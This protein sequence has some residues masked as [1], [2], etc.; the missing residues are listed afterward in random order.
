ME[1]PLAFVS[2]FVALAAAQDSVPGTAG[3]VSRLP[4]AFVENA[5]QWDG[6]VAFRARRGG[7]TL[8]AGRDGFLLRLVRME[9]EE[10]VRGADH[11]FALV[12]E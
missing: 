12:G 2:L 1:G 9:D 4:L 7:M 5:G 8:D 6:E 11:P 10:T 3:S